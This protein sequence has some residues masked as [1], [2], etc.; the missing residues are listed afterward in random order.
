L[1]KIDIAAEL[2]PRSAT[3]ASSRSCRKRGSCEL[4]ARQPGGRSSRCSSALANLERENLRGEHKKLLEDITGYL[5]LLSD[6]ANIR[7]VVREDMVELKKKYGDE[8]RTV[9][10][11]DELYDI[12]R[13][14]LITE[15]PMVVTLSH[16]GYIKR[17]PLSIYQAQNGG[18]KGIRGAK[19]DEEDALAHLFVASTHDYLLF[20]TDRGKVH[21]QKVYDLPLQSRTSKGRA[22]VNLLSLQD[23]EERVTSCLPVR[24]SPTIA[25]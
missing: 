14:D 9:I 8:R 12:D 19:S 4:S 18:G 5:Q 15:E 10:S 23:P 6:E 11:E 22:V 16:E 3:T 2:M 21:W 7:A 25:S 20:F 24:D 17:T 1:Q 13:G